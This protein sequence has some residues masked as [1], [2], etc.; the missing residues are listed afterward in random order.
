MAKQRVIPRIPLSDIEEECTDKYV[1]CL[2]DTDL[3]ELYKQND[4]NKQDKTLLIKRFKINFETKIINI[5]QNI[6]KVTSKVR[7]YVSMIIKSTQKCKILIK[8]HI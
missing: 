7:E 1:T 5:K 3:Q 8:N 2:I 4:I 6:P